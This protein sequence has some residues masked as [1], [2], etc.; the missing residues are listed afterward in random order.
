MLDVS[1]GTVR[2]LVASGDLPQP[3]KIGS[4]TARW[5]ARDIEAYLRRLEFEWEQAA[6]QQ[7]S[8]AQDAPRSPKKPQKLEPPAD[9]S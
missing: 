3:V 9:C 8:A 6:R 1:E 5:W 4:K 7:K 2:N